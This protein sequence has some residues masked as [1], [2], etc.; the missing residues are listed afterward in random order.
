MA[1]RNSEARDAVTRV[2]SA[3][4]VLPARVLTDSSSMFG[5]SETNLR[6]TESFVYT[7]LD[8]EALAE[9][10]G[11]AALRLYSADM[12][13]EASL[14]KLHRSIRMVRS[15]DSAGGTEYACAVIEELPESQRIEA[16]R[17]MARAVVTATPAAERDRAPVAELREM[18][19]LPAATTN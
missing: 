9:T 11:D 1:G 13:R 3:V 17:E 6:H 8:D 19:A 14:V 2:Q 16:V 18:L 15:G 7:Y 12:P 5:W 10:A 4:E